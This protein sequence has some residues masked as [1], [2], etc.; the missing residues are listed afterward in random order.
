MAD[1]RPKLF[2]YSDGAEA[3]PDKTEKIK[4]YGSSESI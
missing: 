3:K 2:L 1:P 4:T